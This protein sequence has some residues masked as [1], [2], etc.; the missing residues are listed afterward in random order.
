MG[1][2]N[3]RWII[4]LKRNIEIMNID[5]DNIGA[6]NRTGPFYLSSVNITA[7]TA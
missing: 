5:I 6:G 1:H 2:P 3:Y 7:M 4:I